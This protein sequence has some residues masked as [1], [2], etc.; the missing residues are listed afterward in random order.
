M[1]VEVYLKA[2]ADIDLNDYYNGDAND[3]NNDVD[4]NETRGTA[5]VDEVEHNKEEEGEE[6]EEDAESNEVEA[7][8][9]DEDEGMNS[10]D[11]YN[12][13]EKQLD[14]NTAHFKRR[15]D[16]FSEFARYHENHVFR[17]R[18]GYLCSRKAIG[19]LLENTMFV[20]QTQ[21]EMNRKRNDLMGA[22]ERES[23]EFK[24]ARK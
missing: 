5:R 4:Y 12:E 16:E 20:A 11:D 14:Y 23:D 9:E 22:K 15:S 3:K 19:E 2:H 18:A 1:S 8:D 13:Q 7:E 17:H 10:S 24:R 21:I 6:E